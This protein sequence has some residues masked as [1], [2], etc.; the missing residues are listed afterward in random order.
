LTPEKRLFAVAIMLVYLD[1][2]AR[3]SSFTI[4]PF[5]HVSI[6]ACSLTARTAFTQRAESSVIFAFGAID[7]PFGVTG[8]H[9][10]R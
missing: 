7:T 8:D 1:H 5:K 4:A 2:V 9:L 6:I 10:Y 3:S